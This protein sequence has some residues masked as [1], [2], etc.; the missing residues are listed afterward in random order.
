MPPRVVARSEGEVQG[1]AGERAEL[2]CVAH[3]GQGEKGEIWGGGR[4]MRL[5]QCIFLEII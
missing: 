3:G 5:A 4:G 1:R 2:E